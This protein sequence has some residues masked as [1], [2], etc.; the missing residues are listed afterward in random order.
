[1]STLEF[2]GKGKPLTQSAIDG[3]VAK[4]DV[5]KETFWAVMSVETS[6]F[7]FLPDRRPMIL[8]ERHIFQKLTKG[9]HHK[10]HPDIS[11]PVPGGYGKKDRAYQYE[12]LAKAIKLDRTAALESVSWGLG[13]VMGFNASTAGYASV[14][15]M[16]TAMANSEDAQM[17][18]M[19]AF[20]N[21][22]GLA[23]Y[24]KG[25]NWAAFANGYNGPGYKKK[26]YDQKLATA[27]YLYSV[28]PTPESSR[29]SRAGGAPVS[30]LRS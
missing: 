12:R 20:I 29:A 25:Q 7:G 26:K 24:L 9:I 30:R 21:K 11:N 14:E 2:S 27:H 19:A 18:G 1:M 5:K 10:K 4:L 3:E 22:N 8:Y 16:V 28:A 17:A 23:G 15:G 6:G 13:Q